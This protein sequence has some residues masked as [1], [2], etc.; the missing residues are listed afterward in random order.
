[1]A[2]NS[3]MTQLTQPK[4]SKPTGSLRAL[5]GL[6]QKDRRAKNS[7][8][9]ASVLLLILAVGIMMLSLDPQLKQWTLSDFN[10]FAISNVTKKEDCKSHPS[11]YPCIEKENNQTDESAIFTIYIQTV[12]K[13][14]H[15][16][17]FYSFI[18]HLCSCD[19]TKDRLWTL[20]KGSVPRFYVGPHELT[21]LQSVYEEVRRESCIV[22][23][24]INP[25]LKSCHSL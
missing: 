14:M 8:R 12:W 23:F 19:D 17:T 18:H 4:N 25:P 3:S 1:M 20:P 13:S 16:E 24:V 6:S 11:R 2:E 21:Y 22:H 5:G 15:S 7:T 9:A 10:E